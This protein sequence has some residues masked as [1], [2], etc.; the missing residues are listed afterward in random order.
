MPKVS[1]SEAARLAGKPR[2][3]IHRHI[4]Q[5]KISKEKNGLGNPVIDVAELERVYGSFKE[6]NTK[7]TEAKGHSETGNTNLADR[8]ELAVL[9]R[10]VELLNGQISY[11]QE[12]CNHWRQQATA[13][14]STPQRQSLWSKLFGKD[15]TE[16][17]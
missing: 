9:R 5:G 17:S 4:N 3:T 2:S 11:L 7:Q 16:S 1:I 13:L 6:V 8:E 15:R 12:S 14:L 10:E